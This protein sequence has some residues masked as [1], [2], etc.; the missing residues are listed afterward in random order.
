L[1][2][3]VELELGLFDEAADKFSRAIK[4]GDKNLIRW[5]TYGEGVALLAMAQRDNSEGKAGSAFSLASKAI[6]SCES[7]EE[8][9]SA[10]IQKLLGDL[11]T[12]GAALPDDVFGSENVTTRN[13]LQDVQ[14]AFIAN[15]E[16]A[17]AGAEQAVEGLTTEDS[18][19]QRASFVTDFGVNRLLQAQMVAFFQSRGLQ[20]RVRSPKV[21]EMFERAANEFRR[22]I[23]L[24]PLYAPAWCGLGCSV[25]GDAPLLAQHAFCR[26]IELDQQFPDPYSNL[27]FLY[28]ENNS[29]FPSASVSDALTQIADTP[30]MWINRALILE[31][32]AV[33]T[34]DDVVS[35]PK[36]RQAADAYRAALQVGKHPS[37]MLGLAMTFRETDDNFGQAADAAALESFGYTSEYIGGNSSADL[38]GSIANGL[39]LME[40]GVKEAGPHSSTWI[41]EGQHIVREGLND[42]REIMKVS[43]NGVVSNLD[44]D[45][46]E[47]LSDPPAL[48]DTDGDE[49][50]TEHP[51]WKELSLARKIVHEPQRGDLWL[52]LAKEL[53]LTSNAPVA[54]T[55][56]AARRALSIL[57]QQLEKSDTRTGSRIVVGARDLSES[58][59]LTHWLE[60]SDSVAE[61]ESGSKEFIPNVDLQRSLLI[62]PNNRLAREAMKET[63]AAYACLE[64]VERDLNESSA[65]RN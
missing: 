39:L 27:S 46:V 23:E 1:V 19:I 45:L 13:E 65:E 12:F 35:V 58:L 18:I 47:K 14:L 33:K 49:H 15:G 6:K 17:Y 21:I 51:D 3:S 55:L 9:T 56:A 32:E 43:E 28:T 48:C 26:S 57:T 52:A 37:A 60:N 29:F 44:L 53:A 20:E 63:L 2:L 11:Y 61:D 7:L 62:C 8:K 54:S 24:Y 16:T 25:A 50:K 42:I 41:G 5:A 10:A 30:M 40:L 59:A 31:R 22:A 36:L 64:P 34:T 38:T 4:I